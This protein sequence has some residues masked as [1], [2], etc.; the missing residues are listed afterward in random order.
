MYQVNFDSATAVYT[1]AVDFYINIYSITGL[2][3]STHPFT[4]LILAEFRGVNTNWVRTGIATGDSVSRNNERYW[5]LTFNFF[6]S[7]YYGVWDVTGAR[8][9]G[10][11]FLPSEEMY[12][13]SF[14]YQ[15]SASNLD[16]ANATKIDWT[17]QVY[18]QREYD[19]QY[20]Q[21]PVSS[22]TQY[23]TNDVSSSTTNTNVEYGTQTA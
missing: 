14:Y 20:N 3:D 1:K 18:I 22:Y 16:V 10:K 23:S 2:D 8:D 11:V 19:D 15:T 12:N 6:N 5:K 17:E 4:N 13:V 21:A 7:S 9:A